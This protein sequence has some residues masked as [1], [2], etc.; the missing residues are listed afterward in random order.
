MPIYILLG[1]GIV[2]TILV[3][4]PT[5]IGI[6]AQLRSA[7]VFLEHR[8]K[9]EK[10]RIGESLTVAASAFIFLTVRND[11]FLSSYAFCIRQHSRKARHPLWIAANYGC[12]IY[13]QFILLCLLARRTQV[14]KFCCGFPTLRVKY[15][16]AAKTINSKLVP[17]SKA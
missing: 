11:N 5:L 16:I 10:Y 14:S 3:T 12:R 7:R 17:A 15:I 13:L 8:S 4:T 2:I 1:L 9:M 6:E